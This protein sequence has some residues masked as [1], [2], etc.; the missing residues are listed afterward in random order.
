VSTMHNWGRLGDLGET[1][2]VPGLMNTKYSTI[3]PFW[4]DSNVKKIRV[5]P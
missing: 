2:A 3:S 1:G 5:Y 4:R